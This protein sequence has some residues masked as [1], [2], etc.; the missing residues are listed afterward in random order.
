MKHNYLVSI[1]IPCYNRSS[2]IIDTIKSV[3]RQTHKNWECIIV[4]D[5][6]T[7]DTVLVLEKNL[8]NDKRF[9][10]LERPSK[11]KKGP[12][13]CR[14]YGFIHSKGDFV[15][16][17]DSDDLLNQNKLEVDLE[18]INKDSVDFTI[19]Q[20]SFFNHTTKQ[21]TGIWNSTLYSNN[22][23]NDFIQK[24][25]GWGV[26][27]PLWRKTALLKN[28]LTFNEALQ[29]RNDYFY[30]VEAL[31]KRMTP[32]VINKILVSQREHLNRIQNRKDKSDA[33]SIVN[34]YLLKNARRIELDQGVVGSLKKQSILILIRLLKNKRFNTAME[35]SYQLLKLNS[36]KRN[37]GKIIKLL[38]FG[39]FYK[40]TSFGYRYLNYE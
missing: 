7:D 37:S 1:I 38:F 12:S 39:L 31:I 17:L 35:F 28:N 16:W 15:Q 25:I 8:K 19:S 2:L 3:K 4:D 34:L 27:S 10:I 9:M 33:K 6:S 23:L 30:H 13:S 40:I 18:F 24:K 26:N 36:K 5:G 14:N 11:L 32:V 20:S 29:N 22:P 21:P